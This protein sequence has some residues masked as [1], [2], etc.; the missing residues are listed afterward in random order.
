[1][2]L[3]GHLDSISNAGSGETMRAPGAD[4]DASGIA[5]M[6]E[7]LRAMIASGYKPRRT[8]KMMGYAAEEVGLRGSAAMTARASSP[9]S[10]PLPLQ[11]PT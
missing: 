6:T 5:S 7:A 11:L 10:T 4:D 8:I 9:T 1:M 3:G 2:V